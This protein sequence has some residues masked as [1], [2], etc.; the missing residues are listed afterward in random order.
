MTTPAVNLTDHSS[1][2]LPSYRYVSH[3]WTPWGHDTVDYGYMRET[4]PASSN[5]PVDS[6]KWRQP[7]V[8]SHFYLKVLGDPADGTTFMKNDGTD[9][10]MSPYNP[11]AS[12]LVGIVTAN[13]SWMAATA[14][15]RALAQ[16][17]DE[18]VDLASDVYEWRQSVDLLVETAERI[19][20]SVKAF[21][22]N[23]PKLW[24]QVVKNGARNEWKNIPDEWLKLQ[25]GWKPGMSDIFSSCSQLS[26]NAKAYDAKVK[27]IVTQHGAAYIE[28]SSGFP[29]DTNENMTA[30]D[31]QAFRVCKVILYYYMDNPYLAALASL[32]LTNPVDLIW[33]EL[34]YS[35]VVDWFLPIGNWLQSW[36]AGLGWRFK[37]GTRTDLVRMTGRTYP[38][39]NNIRKGWY[40]QK[41]FSG[42][43]FKG[44]QMQRSVYTSQPGVGLP[45]FKNPFTSTHISE[46]LSLL[47]N[48][49]R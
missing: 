38:L 33:E 25:Y 10:W 2:S 35:F 26:T 32:G 20:N 47:V 34:K 41:N 24:G 6:D 43:S 16:L 49:F 39:S 8:W 11:V 5:H 21:R 12:S 31:W 45:H 18:Q 36:D 28:L 40:I 27:G 15:S 37:S 9:G 23:R 19:T 48:A 30:R 7:G 46:G 17:K 4:R 22:R 42:L 14:V 44:M 29:F 1:I 13:P 3:A